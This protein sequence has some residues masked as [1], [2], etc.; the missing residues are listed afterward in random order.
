MADID[1]DFLAHQVKR[2]LDEN[3]AIRAEMRELREGNVNLGR[4]LEHIREDVI[5][6]MKTELG[7]QFASF[8]ARLEARVADAVE[9]GLRRG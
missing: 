3:R 2:V 5:I 1:L 9:E 8:E 6:A 7:G 4:L